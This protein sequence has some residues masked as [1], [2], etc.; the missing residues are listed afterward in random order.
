MYNFYDT[1]FLDKS[2]YILPNVQAQ[3]VKK[4]IHD[5]NLERLTIDNPNHHF[6]I[7]KLKNSKHTIFLR[8]PEQT[9]TFIYTSAH[10]TL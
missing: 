2:T 10:S 5:Q 7:V 8:D 1:T 4:A 3:P 6:F 9:Q